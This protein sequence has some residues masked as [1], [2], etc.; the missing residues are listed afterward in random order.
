MSQPNPSQPFPIIKIGLLGWLASRLIY[1]LLYLMLLITSQHHILQTLYRVGRGAN[2]ILYTGALVV[3]LFGLFRMHTHPASKNLQTW[4]IVLAVCVGLL[5]LQ[6]VLFMIGLHRWIYLGFH[7]NFVLRIVHSFALICAFAL[8]EQWQRQSLSLIPLLPFAGLVLIGNW[9]DTILL[10]LFAVL[11][12]KTSGLI[13]SL[14]GSM[15][16]LL[17]I[18]ALAWLYFG[19]LQ[20]AATREKKVSHT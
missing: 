4:S 18:I 16:A 7:N 17:T 8:F 9:L 20:A 5:A 14:I 15:A 19:A 12:V 10:R 2:D 1:L 6:N 13:Y 11:S 3:F